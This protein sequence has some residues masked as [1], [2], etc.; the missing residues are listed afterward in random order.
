MP[1]L[2]LTAFTFPS[3]EESRVLIPRDVNTGKFIKIGHIVSLIEKSFICIFPLNRG[4]MWVAELHNDHG[5]RVVK[6]LDLRSNG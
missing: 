4:I 3:S 1:L 2:S 6:A 5:G